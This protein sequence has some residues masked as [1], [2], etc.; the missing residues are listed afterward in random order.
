VGFIIPVIGLLFMSLVWTVPE[1]L[2]FEKNQKYLVEIYQSSKHS[3]NSK[4]SY[5]GNRLFSISFYTQGQAE[6]ININASSVAEL[7][8]NSVED[9]LIM[10]KN[11]I[12]K[13]PSE[14]LKHF[15]VIAKYRKYALLKER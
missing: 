15:E 13:L 11:N 6:H 8:N 4:L 12:P 14:L 3:D 1:K 7:S 10:Q 2:N 5:V 9:Y